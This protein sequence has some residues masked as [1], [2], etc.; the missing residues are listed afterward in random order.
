MHNQAINQPKSVLILIN[1]TA[2][3]NF[4]CTTQ[5]TFGT[6]AILKN[7]I[8]QKAAAAKNLRMFFNL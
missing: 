2:L 4:K 5:A 7:P 6:L 3:G 8:C 1:F